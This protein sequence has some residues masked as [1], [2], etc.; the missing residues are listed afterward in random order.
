[1][2]KTLEQ[3]K[4]CALEGEESTM[5]LAKAVKFHKL[6]DGFTAGSVQ[7]LATQACEVL[8]KSGHESLTKDSLH[9]LHD[10]RQ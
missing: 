10:Q 9:T 6:E 8:K 2:L 4:A 7:T 5:P 1:M 3:F